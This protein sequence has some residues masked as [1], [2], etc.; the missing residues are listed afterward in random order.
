MVNANRSA[1]SHDLVNE[2]AMKDD[3][4]LLVITEPNIHESAKAGWI[5]DTV[6]DVILR[7]FSG[8]VA[9]NFKS[10]DEGVL[11]VEMDT[12]VVAVAY[13][14]PNISIQDYGRFL[15][16]IHTILTRE[17]RKF[18]LLGDFNCKLTLAGCTYNNRR[19]ELM[20][21][22]IESLGGYCINDGTSTF[23]ARGHRS[24]LDL[25]IIDGRFLRYQF[26]LT[27]LDDDISSDHFPLRLIFKDSN[28]TAVD[29]LICSRPTTQQIERI[30]DKVTERIQN[31]T[32]LT[33][34]LVTVIIQREMDKEMR[35]SNTRRHVYWWN[36]EIM[37]FREILQ[38][39]RR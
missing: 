22:L 4:D 29:R 30:V 9:L 14:S 26:E 3:T 19:G 20:A 13:V 38:K 18:I 34:E 25:V 31:M 12:V 11:V 6:G 28:Y 33:P 21:D 7:N 2:L 8:R 17:A 37:R 36:N 35:K 23:V 27:V 5:V 1:L 39:A 32:E 15:D 10:R 16:S 24:I